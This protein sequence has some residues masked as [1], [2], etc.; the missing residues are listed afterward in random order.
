[1]SMHH[2][3]PEDLLKQIPG[4]PPG[5]DLLRRKWA[6]ELAFLTSDAD[7]ADQGL[8]LRTTGLRQWFSIMA[9]H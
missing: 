3:Y 8:Y 1:M 9:A 4:P 7:A 2:N 5:L 6:Q